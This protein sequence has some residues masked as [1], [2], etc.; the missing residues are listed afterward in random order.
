VTWCNRTVN[1]N[2]TLFSGLSDNPRMI[3]TEAIEMPRGKPGFG[4]VTSILLPLN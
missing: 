1:K 4:V 2:S 3:G